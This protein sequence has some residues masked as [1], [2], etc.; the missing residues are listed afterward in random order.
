ME[1]LRLMSY[2]VE[3]A[4]HYFKDP[5][6][7]YYIGNSVGN[8]HYTFFEADRRVI[9]HELSCGGRVVIDVKYEPD[10]KDEDS[11]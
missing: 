3:L 2:I 6:N 7:L 4:L 10:W 5:S 11:E 1:D 8:C 9:S